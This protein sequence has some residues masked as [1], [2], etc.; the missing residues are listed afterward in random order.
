MQREPDASGTFG[1]STI[2]WGKT[3]RLHSGTNSDVCLVQQVV[4][5]LS[6]G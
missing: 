6:E 3:S 5:I 2:G 4:G 1:R